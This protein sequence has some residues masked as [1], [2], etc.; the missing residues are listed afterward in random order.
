M[1]IGT[2]SIEIDQKALFRKKWSDVLRVRVESY[3]DSWASPS[4]SDFDYDTSAVFSRYNPEQTIFAK[5]KNISLKN[6]TFLDV[7]CG[8]GR[9]GAPFIE[10]GVRVDGVDISGEMLKKAEGRGYNRLIKRDLAMGS[11]DDL[12]GQYD[13][14]ISIGVLGEWLPPSVLPR[15]LGA[16]ADNSIV[17]I[18]AGL[19]ESDNDICL[20]LL[21]ERGFKIA[22]NFKDF[23]YLRGRVPVDYFYTIAKR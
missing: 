6:K 15:F 16:V 22:D 7:G 14:I 1:A 4:N 11:L 8:T 10:Y 9:S 2:D 17:A 23:S 13:G 19:S 21:E 5:M 18:A 20:S 12:S 3:F